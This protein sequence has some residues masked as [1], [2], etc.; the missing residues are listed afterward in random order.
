MAVCWIFFTLEL[1]V[2]HCADLED[3]GYTSSG[4]YTI[5]PEDGL[6]TIK[7]LLELRLKKVCP[8]MYIYNIYEV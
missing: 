3:L 5:D 2:R 4:V 8:Y 6:G 1:P 7:I